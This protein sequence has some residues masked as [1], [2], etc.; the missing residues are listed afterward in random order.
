MADSKPPKH[1]LWWVSQARRALHGKAVDLQNFSIIEDINM[2]ILALAGLLFPLLLAGCNTV[3]GFGKDVE[4]GGEE[5]Q[6][7]SQNVKEKM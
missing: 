1:W 7:A 6:D 2:K 5:I 4:S 3:E